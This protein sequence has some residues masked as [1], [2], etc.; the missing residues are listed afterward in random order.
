M[1]IAPKKKGDN[2]KLAIVAFF[3]SSIKKKK[4][5]DDNKLVLVALFVAT[6][7]IF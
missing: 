1:V 3:S 4:M 7:I 2:I 6:I 5:G